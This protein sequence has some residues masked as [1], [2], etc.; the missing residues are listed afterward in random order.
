VDIPDKVLEKRIQK[1]YEQKKA[2]I[3]C[4]RLGIKS[5]SKTSA[6]TSEKG[7]QVLVC[8]VLAISSQGFLRKGHGL[9]L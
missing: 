1:K 3:S 5:R 4:C 6:G 9:E 2:G 7:V 8:W